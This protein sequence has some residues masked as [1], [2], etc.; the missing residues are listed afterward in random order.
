MLAETF[1]C[2][3]WREIGAE[4]HREADDARL[5]HFQGVV[6]AKELREARLA[7]V[8]R[9]AHQHGSL[10]LQLVEEIG[11]QCAPKMTSVR[12]DMRAGNN[13]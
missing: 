5:R 8:G 6:K 4:Q 9:R 10:R 11:T 7:R 1:F 13:K 3:C 2:C 12:L